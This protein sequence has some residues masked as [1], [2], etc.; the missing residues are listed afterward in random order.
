MR[1]S[2]GLGFGIFLAGVGIGTAVALLL[3]PRSG[4]E[5]RDFIAE[6]TRRGKDFVSQKASDLRGQVESSVRKAKDKVQ[7]A[8]QVGKDA[9]RERVGQEPI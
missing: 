7:E 6:K 5:T 4:E 9:Y 2:N 3:A 1:D 8:V